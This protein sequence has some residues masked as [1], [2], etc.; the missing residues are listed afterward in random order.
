MAANLEKVIDTGKGIRFK[1][2]TSDVIPVIDFSPM[3]SSNPE[4]RRR[5][6]PEIRKACMEVG[7]F[8][9]KN[10]GIPDAVTRRAYQAMQR[11]FALPRDE[12]VKQ[13]YM[14]TPNHRGYVALGDIK[15]DHELKGEDMHEAFESAHDLPAD[16]PDYLKGIKF[17]GPN[18]W[19]DQPSVP[20][21]GAR[22]EPGG[23]APGR[24]P[25]HGAAATRARQQPAAPRRILRAARP[26]PA[27]WVFSATFTRAA[28]ARIASGQGLRA[29][30]GLSHWGSQ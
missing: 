18:A 7:F 9:L 21:T 17:Y 8:Y 14:T 6:A 30:S 19:P 28:C 2:N 27:S 5:I 23:P 4:E 29:R 13:H 15:A 10:H 20:G 3:L 11:Y 26:P 25:R 24:R 12:K 1:R 16:D 22:A